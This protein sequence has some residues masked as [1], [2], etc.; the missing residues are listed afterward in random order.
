[1]ETDG[2][3]LIT[4]AATVQVIA[5]GLGTQ[6]WGPD[7]GDCWT[8]ADQ[9]KCGCVKFSES[10]TV[11]KGVVNALL[12][13]VFGEVDHS[14]PAV[15]VPLVMEDLL[16]AVVLEAEA[17]TAEVCAATCEGVQTTSAHVKAKVTDSATDSSEPSTRAWTGAAYVDSG[18][19]L[20][21]ISG[22]VAEQLRLHIQP[23]GLA[24]PNTFLRTV[25]GEFM[26]VT[27][28]ARIRLVMQDSVEVEWTC[29]VVPAFAQGVLLGVDF[30]TGTCADMSFGKRTLSFPGQPAI[31]L[32]TTA[33][34]QGQL[35]VEQAIMIAARTRVVTRCVPLNGLP[36]WCTPGHV[37]ET[38]M[39][40]HPKEFM[41]QP[42][43][44]VVETARSWG[45][46]ED[47]AMP[48]QLL[49]PLYE[50]VWVHVG[51]SIGYMTDPEADVM[52]NCTITV[53][54][55][56]EDDDGRHRDG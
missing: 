46:F 10:G 5:T 12:E 45:V 16:N 33:Q 24:A 11:V 56:A 26:G 1:V 44:S 27:G 7:S 17:E 21:I 13:G 55:P 19:A 53:L 20:S 42:L 15:V 41:D 49:N 54:N 22:K 3:S 4:T 51:E 39:A 36:S 35:G 40:K 34:E 6:S 14:D 31:S 47:G 9:R 29:L 18:A 37:A 52:V 2:G 43:R 25:S 48:V 8:C 32:G 23:S 38:G 50:A 28:K 30:L